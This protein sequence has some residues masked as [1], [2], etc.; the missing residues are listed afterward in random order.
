MNTVIAL[1]LLAS[2]CAFAAQDPWPKVHDLKSGTDLRIFKKGV[3]QPVLATYEDL[4]NELDHRDQKER[5]C[6][7]Q[8]AD[9]A[10]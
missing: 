3:R 4:N 2:C 7:S 1:A 5:G 10:H 9:G 8:R 6:D